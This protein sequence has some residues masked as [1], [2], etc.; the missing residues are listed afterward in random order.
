M[1]M[2]N[3]TYGERI[4]RRDAIA[5]VMAHAMWTAC[6]DLM[7]LAARAVDETEINAIYQMQSQARRLEVAYARTWG[8]GSP[9]PRLAR[10]L[11]HL[12]D[13]STSDGLALLFG[14]PDAAKVDQLVMR[15]TTE[16]AESRRQRIL[17]AY[18]EHPNEADDILA[19]RLAVPPSD[20]TTV[21]LEARTDA[22]SARVTTADPERKKP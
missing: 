15:A 13:G 20:V 5:I 14:G 11:W 21:R 16:T 6:F 10:A 12:L 2:D 17:A 18:S 3:E 7:L 1:R 9:Q 19:M 22:P 4:L 8:W